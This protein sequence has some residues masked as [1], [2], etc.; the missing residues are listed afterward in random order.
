MPRRHTRPTKKDS[1]AEARAQLKGLP[2]LSETML[3]FAKPLLDTLSSP[4]PIEELRQVMVI[5][6]VAW[7][8]P[9]YEQRKKPEAVA[10]RTTFNAALAQ[11]PPEIAQILSTMLYSRLTTYAHDPRIGFAEVV[12]EA[13][14]RAQVVATAAL[15]D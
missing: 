3:Q 10:Y 6:T 1:H 11:L 7:N 8:L 14:G 4:P 5:V 2:K 9:I 15:T 12:E 13:N